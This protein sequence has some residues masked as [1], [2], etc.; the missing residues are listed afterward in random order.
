MP[1][2]HDRQVA[3]ADA[4]AGPGALC[5]ELALSLESVHLGDEDL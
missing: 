5:G 2:E 3:L 4:E 1:G